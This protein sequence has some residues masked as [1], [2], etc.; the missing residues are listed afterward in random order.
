MW[1]SIWTALLGTAWANGQSSH[2]W[3]SR[4]AIEQLS[5]G[6]LKSLL[7][8]PTLER[9]W[10]NGTMFPDGG[11]AVDDNY[12]EIAH[13]EPFQHAY[14]DWIR[15]Q[16]QPPWSQEAREHIAFLMGLGSHGLAD[17]AYDAMYFR[18]AYVYDAG[19]MWTE[20]FD[21][22][23]DVT[24]VA[25]TEVQSTVD[26]WVPYQPFIDLFSNAGHS[27]SETIISQGQNRL[28]VAVYWVGTTASQSELVDEYRTQ[29]PW[30]TSNQQNPLFPGTPE[31]E[32]RIVAEYW[33]VLWHRL[34]RETEESPLLF[35]HPLSGSA[36]H[37]V[38]SDDIESGLAMGL[39]AGIDQDNLQPEHITV[40]APNG[41]PHPV[42]VDV[43]YGQNSHIINIDPLDDWSVGVHHVI[44]SADIPLIDARTLG[45]VNARQ[46]VEWTFSTAP[47]H[48]SDTEQTG[49]HGCTA[50]QASHS[51]YWCV[52]GVYG[53]VRRRK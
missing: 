30:G 7:Q 37:P 26:V 3:I 20:S 52:L 14:L 39:V 29:F 35:T 9:H 38:N 4:H 19:G 1:L 27:V 18:R 48:Q 23:T 34:H 2:L 31:M 10:R 46:P 49:K 47:V 22:A 43:F 51:V 41:E 53:I 17:Q 44:L 5:A 21:T 12:G 45:D 50:V 16:Y 40:L 15:E 32:S 33:Q 11:Y 25:E 6:E 24:F 36:G 13:W 42:V 8:D 28:N